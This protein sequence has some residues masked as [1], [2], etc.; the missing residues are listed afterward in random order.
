MRTNGRAAAGALLQD[1]LSE[2]PRFTDLASDDSGSAQLSVL[3]YS[4][5]LGW[6]T[7]PALEFHVGVPAPWR[8]SAL[9][10]GEASEQIVVLDADERAWLDTVV[11]AVDGEWGSTFAGSAELLHLDPPPAAH[12]TAA[13]TVFGPLAI[14]GRGEDS[15]GDD[16]A[17]PTLD[18]VRLFATFSAAVA[19]VEQPEPGITGDP[20]AL[21]GRPTLARPVVL[22]PGDRVIWLPYDGQAEV[23]SGARYSSMPVAD[24]TPGLSLV[25]PRG[26]SRD[27]LYRRLLLAAHEDVD[28]MAVEMLLRNF[29][30]GMWELHDREGSWDDVARA[31]RHRG[32]GVQSGS[33]CRSWATGQVIAPEDSED[34]R[35]VA[36]MLFDDRM[37]ID[38][39]WRRVSLIAQE[40]RRLHR[41]LGRLLSAAI[42]EVAAGHSGPNLQRLSEVCGGLDPNGNHRRIRG[43]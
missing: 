15:L 39:A 9:L 14:D 1:L 36:R 12:L 27:A 25:L 26:E 40:L 19:E 33:T 18:L 43:A 31:L 35:R 7:A 29:R 8:R 28:V 11:Q 2:H 24:L 21:S 38:G 23:L 20:S 37:I 32:S 13:R 30:Q 17:L 41:E 5:K 22:E 42:G 34:V 4:T 16:V 6:T 3:P 10:S